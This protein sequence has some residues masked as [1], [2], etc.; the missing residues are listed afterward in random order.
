MVINQLERIEQLKTQIQAL[1][2]GIEETLDKVKVCE[3]TQDTTED[4]RGLQSLLNS[5]DETNNKIRTAQSIVKN[6]HQIKIIK[7]DYDA[8]TT[9]ID[10][11][12]QELKETLEKAKMPIEGLGINEDTVTFNKIPFAQL[13]TSEKLKVS[14]AIAMAMNPELRVIRI[15]DG[16]LLDEDN[17]KVI[18]QMA[19]DSD[20]QVWIEVVDSSGKVGIYIEDGEVVTVNEAENQVV[21][22]DQKLGGILENN[23]TT[24]YT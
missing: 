2:R 23:I 14:M 20:F 9:S 22:P 4:I 18:Q 16:S 3:A 24:H 8:L 12:D 10:K 6:L 7:G 5:A 17:M 21:A 11:A 13:S 19:V 1:Q 15:L